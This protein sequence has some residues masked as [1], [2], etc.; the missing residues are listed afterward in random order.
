[1]KH[2]LPIKKGF[3]PYR[4]PARNFKLKIVD[5]VKEEVNRLLQVR[6]MHP[7]HYAEWVSNIVPVEKK[8]TGKI[9]VCVYFQNLNWATPK[10]E[11]PMPIADMLINNASGNK[12]ISFLGG[13]EGYNQIFMA[14]ED[15]SKT[16]FRCLGFVGLFKWVVM[17]FGL[18][19]VGATYQRAMNLIFH[20]MLGVLLEMYIGNVVMKSAGFDGH[21]ADLRVALGKMRKYGLKMNPLK[22]TF[23]VSTGRFLGFIIH[24]GGIHVDPKKVESIKKLA[25]PTCWKDVQKLL[26][27]VNYLRRF[28]SNLVGR[29]ETFLPIVRL[30]HN[31]EFVWGANQRKSFEKLK[32]YLFNAPVLRAPKVGKACKLYIAAQPCVIGTML[33]QEEDGKEFIIAYVSRCLLDAETRYTNVEKL[34]L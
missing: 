31:D 24:E 6:F 23:R 4:Q 10:D 1:V 20:D 32:E 19:N 27:K 33:T 16:A 14:E 12:V 22:C 26:G 30:K 2:R 25:E 13:N 34:C 3:K 18:K 11:Y 15:I 17:T 28:I 21:L 9:R 29:V 5:K 7:C 8:N